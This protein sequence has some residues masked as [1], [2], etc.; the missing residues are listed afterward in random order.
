MRTKKFQLIFHND[1]TNYMRKYNQIQVYNY[2]TVLTVS[3]RREYTY[4]IL[5]SKSKTHK[6]K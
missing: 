5:P 4:K 6:K 3:P 2:V 1:F